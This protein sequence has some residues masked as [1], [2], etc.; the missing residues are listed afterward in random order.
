M[1]KLYLAFIFLFGVFFFGITA[2]RKLSGKEQLEL[3]KTLV[4]SIVCSVLAFASMILIVF[5]F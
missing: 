2:V 1:V 4:Y 5:L 3:T